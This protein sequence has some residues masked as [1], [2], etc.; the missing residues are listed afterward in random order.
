MVAKFGVK[1]KIS[2]LNQ[3]KKLK[4]IRIL[5]FKGTREGAEDLYKE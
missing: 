1:E 2:I 4:T 5:N 3:L